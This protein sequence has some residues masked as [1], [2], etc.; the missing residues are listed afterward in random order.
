MSYLVMVDRCLRNL[1]SWVESR[2]L[3][4]DEAT[5][6]RT[7]F[8][9]NM[10]VDSATA[11]RLMREGREALAVQAHPHNYIHAAMPG[12]SLFM[13]NPAIPLEAMYPDGVPEGKSR[14]RLNVDMSNVPDDQE[15][16]DDVLV[17]SSSK[18]YWI[19]K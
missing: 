16:A 3:W 4:N 6:V 1:T 7:E 13:R 15:Y 8:N 11:A 9:K 10:N 14:R 17:D 18:S 2:D 5:K 12:G 19:N